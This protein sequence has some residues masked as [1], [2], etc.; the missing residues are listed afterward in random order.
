MQTVKF[1]MREVGTGE[2]MLG[3]EEFETFLDYNVHSLGY[4]L[5]DV[6]AT[7]IVKEGI[8]VGKR[9]FLT[10]VKKDLPKVK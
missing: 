10:Y 7:D 6:A 8:F 3:L 1:I 2:G 4:E 9:V 5:F